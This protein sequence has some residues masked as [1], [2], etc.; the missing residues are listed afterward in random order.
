L[1]CSSFDGSNSSAEDVNYP[2]NP[3]LQKTPADITPYLTVLGSASGP[4]NI[5]SVTNV[6]AGSTASSNTATG[7]IPNIQ[8]PTAKITSVEVCPGTSSSSGGIFTIQSV[9][10]S[11]N[12]NNKSITLQSNGVSCSVTSYF[13]GLGLPTSCY[14]Y[15]T[16]KCGSGTGACTKKLS[17]WRVVVNYEYEYESY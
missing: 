4:L 7:N 9:W 11:C 5:M 6:P 3:P 13:N 1:S 17:N 10:V 15:F 8:K 14:V 2:K 12:N 16:G